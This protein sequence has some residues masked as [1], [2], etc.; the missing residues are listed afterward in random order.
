[1]QSAGTQARARADGE[2]SPNQ[3]KKSPPTG[4]I[5]G[6]RRASLA[7]AAPCQLYRHCLAWGSKPLLVV[8]V[9]FLF[10]LFILVITPPRP[11]GGRSRP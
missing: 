5:A 7:D 6:S 3:N 11:V 2:I 1:M 10:L 8:A 4:W 9:V